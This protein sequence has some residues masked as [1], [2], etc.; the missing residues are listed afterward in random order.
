M[1][2]PGD[3]ILIPNCPCCGSSRGSVS[4]SSVEVLACPGCPPITT[5]TVTFKIAS[6]TLF[7]GGFTERV[8]AYN[9]GSD[10]WGMSYSFFGTISLSFVCR[11]S[12]CLVLAGVATSTPGCTSVASTLIPANGMLL[13]LTSPGCPTYNVEVVW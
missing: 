2:N 9:S 3:V 13:V 12:S 10:S 1:P 4:S 8:L 11:S 7:P 6:G 5:T